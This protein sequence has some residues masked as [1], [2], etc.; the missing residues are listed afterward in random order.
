MFPNM[1]VMTTLRNLVNY[2]RE[3][4]SSPREIAGFYYLQEGGIIDIPPSTSIPTLIFILEETQNWAFICLASLILGRIYLK[5]GFDNKTRQ[6]AIEALSIAYEPSRSVDNGMTEAA[7][8]LAL[9]YLG[10]EPAD[11]LI[12]MFA[13]KTGYTDI[14]HCQDDLFSTIIVTIASHAD[15]E[16]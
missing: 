12:R 15:E 2:I 3:H 13:R 4:K 6:A 14:K 11:E 5:R 9:A 8:T 10:Y 1:S 7:K 16:S